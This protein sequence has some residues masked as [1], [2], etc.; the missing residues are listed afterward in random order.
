MGGGLLWQRQGAARVWTDTDSAVLAA[1]TEIGL[2]VLC[3]DR[4]TGGRS[5]RQLVSDR[6]IDSGIG[7]SARA[8]GC[9]DFPVFAG[10]WD[11]ESRRAIVFGSG[12]G[13]PRL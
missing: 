5:R 12:D 1:A 2:V 8:I 3:R 9:G 10:L 13:S 4:D 7:G 6:I 11:R